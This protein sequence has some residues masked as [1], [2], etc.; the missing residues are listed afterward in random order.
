MIKNAVTSTDRTVVLPDYESTLRANALRVL[1]EEGVLE[2]R[3]EAEWD[4]L[5]RAPA[6][7]FEVPTLDELDDMASVTA[8]NPSSAE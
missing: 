8:S 7:S 5:R 4:R 3:L 2:D 1:R 6:A